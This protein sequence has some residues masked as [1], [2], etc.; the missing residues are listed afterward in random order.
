MGSISF[1][2]TVLSL[3]VWVTGC[4]VG[5]NYQRPAFDFT[6]G[7][8]GPDESATTQPSVTTPRPLEIARWWETFNDPVLNSLIRRGI[9]DNLDLRQAQARIRQARAGRAFARGGLW[10]TVDTSA[11]YRRSRSGGEDGD[12][13]SLFDAGLDAAWEVDVFGGLR[14]NVEAAD[15]DVR[16]AVE[17]S[18]DLLVTLASE[19]AIN[20]ADLRLI[21][22]QL[23]IS[24][25]N[26]VAQRRSADLTRRRFAGGFVSGLDV[27]NADAL[28]SGTESQIPAIEASRRQTIYA[29]SVLLGQEPGALL[30]EL[31]AAAPVPGTP[32]QVPIGLPSDLLLRRPDIRRAEARL[33]ASTA[34]IGVA[35]A[36]LFPRFSLTGSFGLSGEKLSDLGNWSS[37][38]WSFGPTVTWPLFDAGRIRANIAI[39]NATQ[40]ESL[41][42]YRSTILLALQEVENA[43]IAYSKEQ[44]RRKALANTV[45]ANRRAV[46]LATQLYTQGQTDFLN[47]LSAQ[48]SLLS[49]EESLAA[50]D[51]TVATNLITLY[52]ALGGGWEV[53]E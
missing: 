37:R 48:R 31:S 41:L 13:R 39:Q 19:I 20:Y 4:L 3:C 16:A 52:K 40:E 47:V 28:V 29:L 18:R 44:E 38:S 27:A 11:A 12:E 23:T 1:R 49:S 14:R 36:D 42:A 45:A 30:G 32:P 33:R 51:R 15:A 9:E 43:L 35:T 34:R 46:E 21:Q 53:E 50:S 8:A 26:L 25:E 6:D 2:A 17:D 5:P 10:P 7:W 24:Q 22:R